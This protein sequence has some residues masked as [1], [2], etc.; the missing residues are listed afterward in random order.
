MQR[1]PHHVLLLYPPTGRCLREDRC[2]IPARNVVMSP[3]LPPTDLL[4]L[5]AVAEKEGCVCRIADHSDRTA[6]TGAM[7]RDLRDFRPRYV[8]IAVTT[9]TLEQDLRFCSALKEE[10]PGAEIIAKGAHA[11]RFDRELLERCP[12]LDMV[13]RGESETTF[14][15]IV[16][17]LDRSRIPGLT[18]RGPD[19]I[20]RN[21]D[22]PF[23]DRLDDLPFPA[24]HLIDNGRYRRPDTGMPQAV[25]KVSRGCPYHCFYCLA[26]PLAGSTV[27]RRSP[28]NILAEISECVE[29]YGIRDFLFWS[30]VFNADRG[31]VLSL[32]EAIRSSGLDI[33]WAANSR[34]DL[35][36]RETAEAMR[37]AGCGLV[38]VGVESGS[39]DLLDRMG[40]RLDLD[41]V[42]RGISV[43]KAAGIPTIAYYQF[44]LPWETRET[45]EETMRVALELD[46]EY[47]NF[48]LSSPLPGTRFHEYA[49][50]Q[51][52][53]NDAAAAGTFP[54]AGAYY[55]PVVRGH[56]LG[57]R[58]ILGLRK[59]AIRGYVYR[60]GYILRHIG[61]IRSWKQLFT[62]A[63]AA[64]SV[65]R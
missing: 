51:G 56:F 22:R 35:M 11:L 8:V 53:F 45:A 38:S 25:I 10:L 9:P 60:P 21:E 63:G 34:A 33:R 49:L 52:L 61:R 14:R 58:D 37:R 41:E 64:C 62:Y 55:E 4:Y 48:F 31:W 43:L 65:D 17:G 47:A 32:C 54:F 30:D 27:R 44:G 5:A 20:R 28:E 36:D 42:R 46:T 2:Q 13:M 24:R 29:T 15:D 50:A 39:Q 59:A 40:K 7:L 19:G 6:V 18:W 12:G 57:T 26:T 3:P 16:A 1:T 23:C